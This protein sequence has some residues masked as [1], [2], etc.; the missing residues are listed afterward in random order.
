LPVSTCALAGSAATINAPANASAI[1][2]RPLP[3]DAVLTRSPITAS[4]GH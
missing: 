3:P 1:P 2:P 4:A